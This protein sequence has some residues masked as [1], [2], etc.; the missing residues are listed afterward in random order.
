MQPGEP[1][2]DASGV[3]ESARLHV[4]GAAT[5]IDD[6]REPAGCLHGAP[7][8]STVA[9]GDI[10]AIDLSAVRAAPDVVAVLT[11]ADIPGRNDIAPAFAD[12][13]V[14]ADKIVLYHG[15]PL[16]IVIARTRDAARRAARLARVSYAEKNPAISI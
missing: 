2:F 13:P 7:G 10:S 1:P 12:E 4:S 11:A 9:H 3:H 14:L 6:I 8:L 16:F 5:Y 15:Q